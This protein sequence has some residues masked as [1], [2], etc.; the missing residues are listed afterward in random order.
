MIYNLDVSNRVATIDKGS[1]VQNNI[2]IDQLIVSLDSEWDGADTVKVVF[3]NSR[4]TVEVEYFG[5]LIDIPWELLKEEG[6]MWIG[7]VGYF[8]NGD[9]LVTKE[10]AT[11]VTVTKSG[12]VEGDD[13]SSPTLDIY[14]KFVANS[15][16]A[17]AASTRANDAASAAEYYTT[18]ASAWT[19][20]P[21]RKVEGSVCHVED[22]F[23]GDVLEAVVY[24]KSVQDTSAGNPSPDNPIPIDSIT[25]VSL[26]VSGE[27]TS[28][29]TVIGIPLTSEDGTAYVL[30]SLPDGTSDK[31][32]VIGGRL[33]LTKMVGTIV[34]DG[35][36]TYTAWYFTSSVCRMAASVPDMETT[37]T[38]SSV[39]DNKLACDK[40]MPSCNE[41][42][43]GGSQGI[44]RRSNGL[45]DLMVS[46]GIEYA[47]EIT[48]ADDFKAYLASNPMTV[49][50]PL[51]TPETIDLGPVD[52]IPAFSE[53]I[54]NVWA[55]SDPAT[56]CSI[57]YIRDI[58][59]ILSDIESKIASLS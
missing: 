50:Y 9:R 29:P 33:I 15:E 48:N 57:E 27:D 4:E 51:A 41:A 44:H 2:S 26:N 54:G 38:T 6:Q 23:I 21:K 32:S 36:Q 59:K 42:T 1:I 45:S 46:L 40:L 25:S 37:N 28:S 31:V 13:P 19:N 39:V 14:Q 35:S 55:V 17:E 3:Y 12:K 18:V 16:A 11:P 20:I 8:S 10:M 49:I 56:E 30:R 7:V 52:T 58:N 43:N 22:A 34:L 24:G 53:L 5:G 47:S